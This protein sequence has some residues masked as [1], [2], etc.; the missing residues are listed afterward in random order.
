[1]GSVGITTLRRRV[2][3]SAALGEWDKVREAAE[4]QGCSLNIQDEESGLSLVHWAAQQ[5]NEEALRWLI[6][7]ECFLRLK[8]K[9]GQVPLAGAKGAVLELLLQSAYSPLE[10]LACRRG[11]LTLEQLEQELVGMEAE[12]LD[13]PIWDEGGGTLVGVLAGRHGS[14]G[15]D[16]V[17]LLQWLVAHGADVEAQDEEGNALL[18]LVDWSLGAATVEPLVTWALSEAQVK[19]VD[20]R[21][22]EGETPAQ[23]CAYASPSGGDA[24]RGL[25]LLEQAGANF[26]LGNAKGVNVPMMLARYHGDGPWIRWCFSQAGVDDK[27]VCVKRRTVADYLELHGAEESEDE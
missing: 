13:E 8:D 27:A 7:K 11:A 2:L 12:Q 25:R 20:L 24:L 22:S 16:A 15:L 26:A 17:P 1:M 21:N 6:G 14:K 23:L 4:V 18:H 10:R 3:E 19:H 9:R 5:G